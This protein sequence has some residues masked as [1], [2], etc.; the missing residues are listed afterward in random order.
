MKNKIVFGLIWLGFILYA[1]IFAPP[2]QPE[3]LDLIQNLSTGNWTGINPLIIA[4]F[5]IMG[6]WPL[7]YSCVLFIDGH[8]QKT[9][10]WLFATL[11]FGV[12]AFAILPYLALRQPNPQFLGKKSWFIKILDSRITGLLL[13][14]GTIILVIYGLTQG[15]WEDFI[16]QWQTSRFIHVMSLDFLLLSI[17]FPVLL[18]DDRARRGMEK[19][20]ILEWISLIPLFGALFYLTTRVPLNHQTE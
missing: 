20:V 19:S 6:I 10:A 12:G 18:T 14:L 3:T 17:L 7:I 8:G 1:F 4:L 9:P 2:D 5:N 16:Q 11:S 13:T 15:N